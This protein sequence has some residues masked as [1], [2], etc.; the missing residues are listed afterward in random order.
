M[1]ALN[2]DLA[3]ASHHYWLQ[4]LSILHV[5]RWSSGDCR[6]YAASARFQRG[7]KAGA[8]SIDELPRYRRERTQIVGSLDQCTQ[9]V[10]TNF[11][12]RRNQRVGAG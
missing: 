7:R 6:I 1:R 4:A 2:F 5:V 10:N 8:A 3:V 12:H 11:G 9:S